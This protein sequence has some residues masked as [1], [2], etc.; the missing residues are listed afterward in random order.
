MSRLSETA[1]LKEKCIV[2]MNFLYHVFKDRISLE[3]VNAKIHKLIKS[4][5]VYV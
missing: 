1:F 4:F 3:Y 2:L 5:Y